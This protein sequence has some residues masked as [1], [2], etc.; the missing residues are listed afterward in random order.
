[1]A[2]WLR[3][4]L[5]HV[6]GVYCKRQGRAHHLTLLP[7]LPGLPESSAG[8]SRGAGSSGSLAGGVGPPLLIPRPQVTG[9][10][11]WALPL[12]GLTSPAAGGLPTCRPALLCLGASALA[13]LVLQH[14]PCLELLSLSVLLAGGHIQAVTPRPRIQVSQREPS[15]PLLSEQNLGSRER[16]SGHGLW[17]GCSWHSARSFQ[18]Y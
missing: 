14:R 3:D 13:W 8:C 17:T 11:S 2:V 6:L 4:P 7:G 5:A 18:K 1:M 10:L 16:A 9:R 15:W 12:C